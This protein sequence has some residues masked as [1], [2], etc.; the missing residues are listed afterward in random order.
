MFFKDKSANSK[1]E[2]FFFIVMT[3]VLLITPFF[4]G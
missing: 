4:M 3:I 1:G 2:I